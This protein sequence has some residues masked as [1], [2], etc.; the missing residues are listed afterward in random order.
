MAGKPGHRR[1]LPLGDGRTVAPA[2]PLGCKTRLTA[3][4]RGVDS[5]V[6]NPYVYHISEFKRSE[7]EAA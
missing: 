4:W 7:G 2:W 1:D 3:Q 6:A 5:A